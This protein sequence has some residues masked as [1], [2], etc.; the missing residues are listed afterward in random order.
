M[1]NWASTR[2]KESFHFNNNLTIRENSEILKSWKTYEWNRG[3]SLGSFHADGQ[4]TWP[5]RLEVSKLLSL[6][7]HPQKFWTS[8]SQKESFD[9]GWCLLQQHRPR[10]PILLWP[11]QSRWPTAACCPLLYFFEYMAPPRQSG[12]TPTAKDDHVHQLDN[13]NATLTVFKNTPHQRPQLRPHV[14]W[15]TRVRPPPLSW[16]SD[17]CFSEDRQWAGNKKP[18]RRHSPSFTHQQSSE[19]TIC[20][21]QESGIWH[22][23]FL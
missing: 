14:L 21:V 15:E 18:L 4:L 10:S 11:H 8:S 7:A 22:L 20:T 17:T 13:A 3:R 5:S 9:G 19:H 12:S 16:L 1:G 2:K 6:P 23:C